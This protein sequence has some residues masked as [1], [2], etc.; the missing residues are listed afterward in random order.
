[1][2]T[3]TNRSRRTVILD[4][5]VED[6][7]WYTG[8]NGRKT[9]P[10]LSLLPGVTSEPLPKSVASLRQVE[11]ALR[12]GKLRLRRHVTPKAK[13]KEKGKKGSKAKK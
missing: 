10:S 5:A 8:A 6:L 2:I 13:P 9:A 3:L 12:I 1:M 11:R 4:L 7:N